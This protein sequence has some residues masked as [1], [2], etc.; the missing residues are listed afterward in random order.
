MP[1]DNFNYLGIEDKQLRDE[2]FIMHLKKTQCYYMVSV[3]PEHRKEVAK[4]FDFQLQHVV[5]CTGGGVGR[6]KAVQKFLAENEHSTFV[7]LDDQ[8]VGHDIF[9][10][11]HVCPQREGLTK[12]LQL[13][14]IK[15]L[16]GELK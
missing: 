15:L 7:V 6:T 16:K 1:Y 14:C 13:K 5:E 9:G 11:N 12:E 8:Q 3:I 4:A 10:E 2:M